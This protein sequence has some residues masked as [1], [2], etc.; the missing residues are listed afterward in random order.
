[1]VL[2]LLAGCAEQPS[3]TTEQQTCARL[4]SLF[5]MM[6]TVEARLADEPVNWMEATHALDDALGMLREN[7][8]RQE[9]ECSYLNHDHQPNRSRFIFVDF[10]TSSAI[11]DT[12]PE[13]LSYLVRIRSIFGEDVEINEYLSEELAHIA[14]AN[15]LAYVRYLESYPSQRQLMLNSTRWNPVNLEKLILKFTDV[16]EGGEVVEF[17]RTKFSETL[18][19][20]T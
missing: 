6:D 20:P 3:G 16:P 12:F 10:L 17:L 7:I 5:Q 14:Y 18:N 13:V 8:S 19:E 1:M 4:D 15:P 2:G 11:R 9:T